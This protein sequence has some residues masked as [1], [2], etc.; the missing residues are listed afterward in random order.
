MKL[1]LLWMQKSQAAQ[2]AYDALTEEQKANRSVGRPEDITL[3]E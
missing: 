3:E 1:K 2:A